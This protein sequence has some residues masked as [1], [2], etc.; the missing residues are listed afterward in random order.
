[1]TGMGLMNVAASRPSAKNKHA[2]HEAISF[3]GV[4]V[5]VSTG[6]GVLNRGGGCLSHIMMLGRVID[7]DSGWSGLS[8]LDGAK[9]DVKIWGASFYVSF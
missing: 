2:V 1:M 7:L 6:S 3:R 8:G 9:Q 4:P 5:F